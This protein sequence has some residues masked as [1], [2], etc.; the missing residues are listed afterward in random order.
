MARPINPVRGMDNPQSKLSPEQVKAC[1]INRHGEPARVWAER[2]HVS[3]TT[4]YKIWRREV[5]AWLR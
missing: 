2:L 4:I 3:Q 5:W 1:K